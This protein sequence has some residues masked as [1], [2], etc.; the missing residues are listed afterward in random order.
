M[1]WNITGRNALVT[2]GNSGIGMAAA[3]ELAARGANVTIAV[4]NRARGLDAAEQISRDA[5]A[6]I[7]ILDLNL[8]DL[9]SV[10]S[11]AASFVSEHNSLSI[12]VNNAGGMFGRRSTTI[13]GHETTFGTNYLGPWLFTYLLTDLLIASAPSRIVNVGSSGHGYAKN[14][15]AFD[16]LQSAGKYKMMSAYGHSKLANIL[17]ARELD[18][19]LSTKGVNAYSMHPGLVKTS[20]GSG[21]DSFAVSLAVRFAGKRM[22]TPQDG[23]D[24]I[25]WLVSEPELPTPTGGY[26]E[27]RAEARSSNHAR[28]D[29][30][31][32]KLWVATAE[33][34]GVDSELRAGS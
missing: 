29:A 9:T 22:K 27:D 21:G 18:R 32:A 14:G 3:T 28:D 26:F 8:S 19:R 2:G 5:G 23:A 10:R 13:D 17:H 33:L 31:A 12:L 16:D 34:L 1:S 6:E 30:M 20:I 4:R 25:A 15:I 11:A 7:G 24:T